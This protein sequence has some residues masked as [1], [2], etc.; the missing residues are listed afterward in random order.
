[1]PRVPFGRLGT[2]FL[3][4]MAIRSGISWPNMSQRGRRERLVEIKD[5]LARAAE[6]LQNSSVYLG[7]AVRIRHWIRTW[8]YDHRHFE[9]LFVFHQVAMSAFILLMT[10]DADEYG[11]YGGLPWIAAYIV[12]LPWARAPFAGQGT[13]VVYR[14][15]L[16]PGG[17]RRAHRQHRLVWSYPERAEIRKLVWGLRLSAPG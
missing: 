14:A 12:D 2:L 9:I 1:M 16:V 8:H 15:G 11:E 7:E 3:S 4:W 5:F 13:A 10:S 17:G 6:R